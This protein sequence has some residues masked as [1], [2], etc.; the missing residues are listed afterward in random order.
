VECASW[1]NITVQILLAPI[2]GAPSPR[3]GLSLLGGFELTGPDGVVDLPSKKLAAL[4]A[5]LACTAPLPQSREKL[6]ALLWGSH[7]DAQAKQ[8]LRQAVSRLRKVL[9]QD[10]LESDG[11]V[12]TL[13]AAAVLCD[14]SRFEALILEG[15]REALSAAANLYR[16]RLIDDV[17]VGEESWNDWLTGERER[18]L[19]LA[20][21]AMMGLGEQELAA[22]RAER[23]LKAGQR[24]IALNNMR[25]DAHRLIVQ[26]LAATGR[27]AEA[28]K[29]YQDLVAL[30]KHELNTGPDAATRSLVAELRSAQL[31]SRA[32][33]VKFAKPPVGHMSRD[34]E[35]ENADSPAE[36][37]DKTPSAVASPSG[38]PERRQLT[39][40]VCNI[41]DSAPL[42]AHLDP[43]EMRDL[44]AAFHKRVADT[45]ARFDGYVAQY[46]SDG[47][48][49]YFGYPAAGEHD[50]EQ[51]L[52]AGLATLDSV[53]TLKAAADVTL[54]ASAGIATGLVFIGEQLN[55]GAARQR[56]AIGETPNLATRLQAVA[57]PG[58]VVI[59]A[60]TRRLVGRKFDCRA[61]AAIEVKG[62]P[63]P[64]EA[65]RVCSETAGVSRFEARRAG[66]LSPLVGRREEIELLLRRWHRAKLGEGCVVLL[67]GEPGIG[68]S[69]IAESLLVRLEGE[70]HARLRYFCSPHHAHSPF[71]PFIAQF[72]QAA[73]F[74]PGSSA[75]TKLDKLEA[76][77]KP[78]AE[79]L[80]RDVTLLAELL[81]LPADERYPA[82]AV[83]PQQKREMTLSAFLDQLASLA[84]RSPVL[85][86]FEDAHWID[87]TSLDLLNRT[88]ARA[89]NLPVL[90][91][92]TAR[93]E[94]QPTWVGEPHV[95][96]LPLNRLGRRDS[97]NIIA[98]VTDKAL[99]DAVV[100]QIL[101][102]ADGVP[103]FIEELT[104]TLIESGV[105]RETADG[106][107]LDGPLPELAVPMTLQAS[108]V[109]RL[110][111][112]GSVKDVAQIGAAIGREFSHELIAAVSALAPMD[113]DA[114]LE[115][116][117]GSGLVSRR[118]TPPDA[119]YSFK[120]ALVQDA[121]Y[122]TMLRSRRQPL[123]ASIATGL[124]ER[125]PALA[126]TLPE[127]VAHHFTEAGLA[128]E[129][130]AYWLKAGQRAAKRSAD[131]EAIIHL[132][133]GL[134]LLNTL[135]ESADRDRRELDFQIASGTPL[136][137]VR[138]YTSSEV[139]AACKRATILSEKLDDVGRLFASLY[140]QFSYCNATGNTYKALEFAERCQTLG[141]RQGDRVMQLMAHRGIGIVLY[142]LGNFASAQKE[143]EQSL[144]LYDPERD[145]SLAARYITDP[146]AS[147]SALLALVA[148]ISG[149]PDRAARM[150]AQALSYAAALNHVNTSG[151]VHFLA[152]AALEQLLGNWAAVLTHTQTLSA[153]AKEHGVLAWQS[154][155]I[156]FEGWAVS[157]TSGPE[158][159]ISLMQ[160][161][162]A[163]VDAKNLTF[164]VP[165]FTS[166]LAQA[167]GR[168]GDFQSA[169]ALCIDA[170]ERAQRSEQYIWEAELHRN[171]G[172][173]RR[174]AGHSLT[175]VEECFGKALDVSRAQ[176][177]RMFELR[178]ATSLARLWRDQGRHVEARN[179]L[180]S[181]YGWFTEG[182]D[183]VD[184]VD[185][186][187]LLTQLR[188]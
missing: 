158:S 148:W 162:I 106:Y 170:R 99:P 84:A 77:L 134:A 103:L 71:H 96:M 131:Q 133:R 184:L 39:I 35:E 85:V 143:L 56:V 139:V 100:E 117:T 68:K 67:S 155:G 29:H 141:I 10:A 136:L 14:V 187:A 176:G 76:L 159:G 78:T 75:G 83:S 12:V 173:V 89:A 66:A 23:A 72:E 49:V 1:R 59:A 40:M 115:R 153:I 18:L 61:L 185:A 165:L 107:A 97:A 128:S 95:T 52:R 142:Q 186:K 30:L 22:G 36:D 31:P 172:E 180:A 120:H 63:Q 108:L 138:G 127:V 65:W 119:T 181:V 33:A 45:V 156:I 64:V 17:T 102:R 124:V 25:E 94:L 92:V 6:S 121:A 20:L 24:V 123:H 82:L 157:W 110:D 74:E 81:G 91:V 44:I 113:L 149:F 182:F 34:G 73:G 112:L 98:G 50:A 7:F 169:L 163:D 178:A 80:P 109:A 90:L 41:V 4:L 86:V 69:R 135:P 137:A 27:K 151:F 147:A 175:D 154:S 179:L 87:P 79:N 70:P 37:G 111:R 53:G 164:F 116:L 152:G 62:L 166:L 11:E 101:A 122:A 146:F 38:N 168:V 57:A 126:E 167:R 28:L 160:K 32:P 21:G 104:G 132:E 13:N 145:R 88:V 42:F 177:A 129:A 2:D 171:E 48:L 43:E 3:F 58:E 19:Q 47:V 46:R 54:Q 140:A 93:P 26:A 9:G 8:N 55:I 60:S 15:S 161:G 51:A 125:F 114:T 144:A 183:T 105:L 188:A 5:Y 174:A 118:G 150:Q 16:G 130:I